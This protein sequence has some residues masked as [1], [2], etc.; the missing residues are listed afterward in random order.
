MNLIDMLLMTKLNHE[1]LLIVLIHG[2]LKLNLEMLSLEVQ[3]D[4]KQSFI[5]L[6]QH[7]N[8]IRMAPNPNTTLSYFIPIIQTIHQL[9]Y[10]LT[11]LLIV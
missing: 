4:R 1:H 5:L 3:N 2:Q 7:S 11:N 8:I 9:I 10:H 6:T